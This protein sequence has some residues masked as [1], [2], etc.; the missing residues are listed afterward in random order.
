MPK[1]IRAVSELQREL[2]QGSGP[3]TFGVSDVSVETRRTPVL[4]EAQEEEV[5]HQRRHVLRTKTRM[6]E[7]SRSAEETV[8][9]AKGRQSTV[10]TRHYARFCGFLF[11]VTGNM[12]TQTLKFKK[13]KKIWRYNC[14]T[15]LTRIPRSSIALGLWA[16]HLQAWLNTRY[17]W[18]AWWLKCDVNS[19]ILFQK[20]SKTSIKSNKKKDDKKKKSSEMVLEHAAIQE[21]LE[22]NGESR[23]YFFDVRKVKRVSLIL[24]VPR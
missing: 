9:M 6:R 16:D 5:P 3:Q 12:S 15:D 8:R 19:A 24:K 13:Y 20:K 7:G 21:P 10:K 11:S 17:S 1:D 22:I 4:Q 2:L 14:I 18:K 23:K